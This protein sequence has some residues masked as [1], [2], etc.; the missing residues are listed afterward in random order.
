MAARAQGFTGLRVV[1]DGTTLADDTAEGRAHWLRWEQLV[2]GLAASTAFVVMCAFDRRR[3]AP[4]V[5]EELCAVHPVVSA[6]PE[7]PPFRVFAGGDGLT[8]VGAVD[9]L[10]APLFRRVLA[11]APPL[12]PLVVDLSA[13]ELLSHGALEALAGTARH[14]AV[15]LRHA[16][17]IVQRLWALLDLPCP[18]VTFEPV[19]PATRTA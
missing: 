19:G 5:V 4:W 7:L 2:D 13:T 11:V 6:G 9:G 16:R 15:V 3:L 1:T 18:E 17:P 14:R 8:L 12:D 10:A